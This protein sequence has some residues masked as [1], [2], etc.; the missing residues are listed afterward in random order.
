M[1]VFGIVM[2]GFAAFGLGSATAR[3]DQTDSSATSSSSP[4]T[5][6]EVLAGVARGHPLLDMATA[7]VDGAAGRLLSAE[8]AFDPTLKASAGGQAG[9]YQSGQAD[10]GLAAQTSFFGTQLEGGWRLGVGDYPIYGG[11]AKTNDGG[12]LRVGVS[13]PLLKDF[14]IDA[15]RAGV[16]QGSLEMARQEAA[17]QAASLSLAQAA[18]SAYFDWLA[19]GARLDVADGLLS[20][21]VERDAQLRVRSASGELASLEVTDN[22]RLIAK[23]RASQVSARRGYEKASLSL[24][25]YVRNDEGATAV[26]GAERRWH[27]DHPHPLSEAETR[28]AVDVDDLTAHAWQNRPELLLLRRQ[29]EQLS[30]ASELANNDILPSLRVGAGVSQDL[31]P[32]HDPLSSSSSVWNPDP[33]TRALPDASLSLAFQLPI[34]LREARGKA[35]AVAAT[36]R[37]IEAQMVA[38]RDRIGLEVQD[39][40]QSVT[41]ARERVSAAT[42]EVAA[43]DAVLAGEVQRYQAGDTTLVV[44]NLRE[45]ALAEARLTLAQATVDVARAEAALLFVQGRTTD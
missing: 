30:V 43:S 41:A 20:L 34:P 35:Q 1:K 10:A 4:L 24:A 32:T 39:A 19:A 12:E 21:A 8:G 29:R 5:L 14:A 9:N 44:V 38:T 25:F 13:V 40:L 15:A 22:A 33:K 16:A 3:A 6:K 2:F 42:E 17:Y 11:K 7:D 18:A 26:P 23:R 31:G 27:L 37:K 36:T 45:V 28:G